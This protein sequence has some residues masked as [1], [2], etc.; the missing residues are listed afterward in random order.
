MNRY[1]NFYPYCLLA[2]LLGFA[3]FL[4]NF[5][6]VALV[7]SAF[8]TPPFIFFVCMY[9]ATHARQSSRKTPDAL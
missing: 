8:L 5:L 7:A 2:L 9:L 1:I 3:A 4:Y 6:F